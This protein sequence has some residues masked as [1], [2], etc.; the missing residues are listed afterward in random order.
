VVGF[1]DQSYGISAGADEAAVYIGYQDWLSKLSEE[2]TFSPVSY[3]V[4]QI[5]SLKDYIQDTPEI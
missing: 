3:S 2:T 1:F 5:D 4:D